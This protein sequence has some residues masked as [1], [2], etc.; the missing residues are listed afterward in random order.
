MNPFKS[1]QISANAYESHGALVGVMLGQSIIAG[2][3]MQDVILVGLLDIQISNRPAWPTH[4][5][6]AWPA[7]TLPACEP[8]G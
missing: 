4:P 3:I 1:I 8:A 6:H 7:A 5:L 2:G